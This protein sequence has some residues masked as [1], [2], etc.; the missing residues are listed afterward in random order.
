[1]G[2]SELAK[3][4]ADRLG[5]QIAFGGFT[6]RK[7]TEREVILKGDWARGD[8]EVLASHLTDICINYLAEMTLQEAKT[9]FKTFLSGE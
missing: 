2:K 5:K 9:L 4:I 1:M 6:Q 3:R 8:M 7:T